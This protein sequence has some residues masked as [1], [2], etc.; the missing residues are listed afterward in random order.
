MVRI[1]PRVAI[2]AIVAF[3]GACESSPVAPGQ[4]QLTT[5]QA[6][7][8]L[9]LP[10][11]HHTLGTFTGIGPPP[12]I[13]SSACPYEAS[14]ESFV[15]PPI[16]AGG[17]TLSQSFTL[18]SVA[19]ARQSAFSSSTTSWLRTITTVRGTVVQGGLWTTVDGE[20]VLTL[21]GLLTD[22]HTLNG[23]S[24]KRTAT[25]TD[26]GSG[27][28]PVLGT[29]TTKFKNVVIPVKLPGTPVAWPLSGSAEMQTTVF[30]DYPAPY[31]AAGPIVGGVVIVFTGTS[32]VEVAL[33][34]RDGTLACHVNMAVVLGLG[35][36]Y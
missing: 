15:C 9:D 11:L 25:V 26:G 28:Q 2:L 31:P 18:V 30:R 35:C 36:Q 19:G 27:E 13:V 32:V 17:L 10:A 14:S 23:S 21:T 16:Q 34:S 24:T 22:R 20:Q 3:V 1:C 5:D 6:L 12:A 29:V 33:T 7:A 4:G 8:E